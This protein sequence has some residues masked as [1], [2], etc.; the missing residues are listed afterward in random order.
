LVSLQP[1]IIVT[2]SIAATA[3]VQWETQTIPIVGVNVRE[4]VAAGLASAF[5]GPGG[6]SPASSTLNPR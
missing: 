5:S 2:G 6:I 1:D 3:A 4:F